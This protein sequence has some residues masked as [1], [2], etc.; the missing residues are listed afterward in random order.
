[1]P[2]ALPSTFCEP[3]VDS[4][5]HVFHRGLT[6]A[7]TRRYKPDYDALPAQYVALLDAHRLSH[8]VL[9]QPSFLGADNSY[10]VGALQAS[11]GR[12]RGV[13]VVQPDIDAAGID[14]L[15][16]AGVV[17]IRLNLFGMP[18]P[19]LGAP[20]WR[21]LLELVNAAHW[22]VEVHVPAAR[23]PGVLPALLDAG[24]R[25]VV[26]HFGR[27]DPALGVD[28]P[29]FRFLLRQ[30]DSRRVWVKL[31]APYRTWDADQC[32]SAPRAAAQQ[33]LGAFG[34]E[35]LMWGSD[36]PHTEHR[37]VSYPPARQWLEAWVDDPTQRRILLADT[38]LRLFQ[39]Q[40]EPA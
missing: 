26:D 1:M 18:D 21:R 37:H 3:A 28:D 11:E 27:P 5:A 12:L 38:P 10:M 8:G 24:C 32:A 30:A 9:V 34:A 6:L 13:A 15:A 2:P 31:S 39:F 29:G 25:V 20:Q 33:L 16:R 36:W 17:G 23:L 35:R 14:A 40:R 19:E 4:H 7:P 22:H